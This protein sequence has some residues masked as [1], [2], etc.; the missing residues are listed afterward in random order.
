LENKKIDDPL[1]ALSA[2]DSGDG[3][4]GGIS[5]RRNPDPEWHRM[6]EKKGGKEGDLGK[7]EASWVSGKGL[8]PSLSLK[9]ARSTK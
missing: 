8:T 4:R 3:R 1:L 7:G 2:R 5:K 6:K 9:K